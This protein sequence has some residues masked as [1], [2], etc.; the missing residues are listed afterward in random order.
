MVTAEIRSKA[1][2]LL[3]VSLLLFVVASIVRGDLCMLWFCET[4]LCEPSILAINSPV[5]ST[6][7]LFLFSSIYLRLPVTSH[8]NCIVE[9]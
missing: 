3:F 9:R 1:M 2:I 8:I 5:W 4:T 7:V 6:L